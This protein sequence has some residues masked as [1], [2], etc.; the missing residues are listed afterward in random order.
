M[1]V[2]L[3]IYVISTH[4]G[5]APVAQRLEQPTIEVCQDQ[6]KLVIQQMPNGCER[7][8]AGCMPAFVVK[9]ACV[10]GS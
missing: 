10:A 5:V 4:A 8:R 7:S 6:A 2:F 3:L 1:K 9:T